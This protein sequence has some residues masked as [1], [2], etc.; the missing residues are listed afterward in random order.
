M[1]KPFGLNSCVGY[2]PSRTRLDRV[3]PQPTN[4]VFHANPTQ[5]RY[6]L[7][8][9]EETPSYA[10]PVQTE[11]GMPS[12]VAVSSLPHTPDAV[13]DAY[14]KATSGELGPPQL[15]LLYATEHHDGT[16]ALRVLQ[17]LA[18]QAAVM[19]GTSCIGVLTR[20]GFHRGDLGVFCL[21]DPQGQFGAALVPLGAS[22]A[23]AAAQAAR[24]ATAHAGRPGE[25]PEIVWLTA[26][27]GQEEA[28]MEGIQSTL[29]ASVP[30]VGGSSADDTIAGR[31]MQWA[32]HRTGSDSVALMTLFPSC[33]M[34]TAFASGY[35]PTQR[36]GT[37]TEAE[38]RRLSRIDDLP[39]A[40]W[41]EEGTQGALKGLDPSQAPN[42]LG[43]T[44]FHPLGR[45]LG[46]SG[47]IPFYQLSHP[48]RLLEDGSLTLFTNIAAGDTVI[49]MEGSPESLQSR[50]GR[51]A[52]SAVRNARLRPSQVSG[53]L[54]V[55]CGGCMLAIQEHMDAVRKGLISALGPVPF[56]TL[57]TFGEQGCFPQSGNLHGN[58]MISVTVFG[59]SVHA[60]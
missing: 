45:R 8:M 53:A 56:L 5:R 24:E 2:N 9:L 22:P 47:G 38:G 31:W 7:F 51:V 17:T 16:E 20:D 41:Y 58:L 59:D 37:V 52:A 49:L 21:W 43:R 13:R 28:V 19:G 35:E 32:H 11:S 10:L 27:P 57:F 3:H 26:A 40:Q 54:V 25:I 55:F 48:E 14:T 34:G 42:I 6:S 33:P 23:E 39:A 30:I 1:L 29:G 4:T 44:T 15:V 46:E 18:P 60:G 36:T 12:Q 50:A